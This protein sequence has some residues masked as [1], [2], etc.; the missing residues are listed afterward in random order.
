MSKGIDQ[1]TLSQTAA[2]DHVDQTR[3]TAVISE[4]VVYFPSWTPVVRNLLK[5][6]LSTVSHKPVTQDIFYQIASV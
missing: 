2:V 5:P 4:S 1:H 6:D 3:V